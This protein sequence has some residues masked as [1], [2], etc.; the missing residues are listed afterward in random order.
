MFRVSGTPLQPAAD[1]Q[2]PCCCFGWCLVC[3][4]RSVGRGGGRDPPTKKACSPL[5]RP[6]AARVAQ[7][8]KGSGAIADRCRAACFLVE[9]RQGNG[10]SSVLP[11]SC[12]NDALCGDINLCG[13][14][15]GSVGSARLR[16]IVCRKQFALGLLASSSL[17]RSIISSESASGVGCDCFHTRRRQTSEVP[18]EHPFLHGVLWRAN[19]SFA[20]QV[21]C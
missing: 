20:A 8:R 11:P 21:L 13:R 19:V 7:G 14:G 17:L 12:M 9:H 4:G 18:H 5:A 1:A 16:R 2:T 3:V 15:T 10:G 6:P